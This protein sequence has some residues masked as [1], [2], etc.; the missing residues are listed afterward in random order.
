[1][2]FK[3]QILTFLLLGILSQLASAQ[4]LILVTSTTRV[5]CF[6]GSDGTMTVDNVFLGIPPYEY[7][8]FDPS[9]DTIP[10][11]SG[12]SISGL[13]DSTYKVH[14][15][16]ALLKSGT[17]SKKVDGGK[18]IVI[19]LVIPNSPDCNGGSDGSIAIQAS[20]AASPITY[21]ID[22]GKTYQASLLFPSLSA[23][24]YYVFVQ[25]ADGCDTVHI[26]NP[27][28][29]IDPL[30]LN[31]TSQS[32]VPLKCAGAPLGEISIDADGGTPPLAYALVP[33]STDITID[34]EY[35]GIGPGSYHV[36]V[37]DAKG[38]TTSSNTYVFSYPNPIV[39]TDVDSTQPSCNGTPDGKITITALGGTGDLYYNLD[40]GPTNTNGIFPGLIAG[41]YDVSITDD[42][43]CG[44]V[45]RLNI[46]VRDPPVISIKSEDTT[47]IKCNLAM[48]GV[49]TVEGE[50]GTPPYDYTLL[51]PPTVFVD[52]DPSGTFTGFPAANGYYV[53]VTDANNC[54]PDSS[55][56]W[57]FAEPP[58]IVIDDTTLVDVS[59][60]G[61]TNGSIDV[62]AIGGTGTLTY[63]ISGIPPISKLDNDDGV[64]TGLPGGTYSVSV[65]DSKTCGPTVISNLVIID[66]PLLEIT[67]ADSTHLLCNGDGNGSITVYASGGTGTR[68]FSITGSG[69]PDNTLGVFS[70]L[71]GGIY[72]VEVDDENLCGPVSTGNIE[73]LEPDL[74]EIDTEDTTSIKCNLAKDG[75]ITVKGK[76]GT[77]PYD[78]TLL[79][80]P[81]VF[82][83][84]DPSGT[85]TGFPAA[86]GY[87][88]RVTDA[89]NCPPDSSISWD[90]AEPSE[91]VIDDTTLADISCN[92]LT[93]GSI[94]V[95]ASGGATGTLIYSIS[96]APP[97]SKPDNNDGIFTG[98]PAGTYSV[99]VTNAYGCGP[100]V[101]NNLVINEPDPIS[102]TFA[103][104]INITCN[105]DNDG[106]IIILATGGTDP[107]RY[108]L[109]DPLNPIDTNNLGTF[110][111]LPGGVYSVDVS[112]TNNC[113]A[114]NSGNLN[115]V[116]P[117]PISITDQDTTP[118]ICFE[119]NNGTI[120][121][122]ASGGTPLLVYSLTPGAYPDNNDGIFT[123]IVPDVGYQVSVTDDNGCT[124]ALSNKW[125]FFEPAAIVLTPLD[126]NDVTC[127]TAGDGSLSVIAAEG[128]PPYMYTLTPG[129]VS[130]VN[131]GDFYSL[132]GDTYSVSVTD[133][134]ACPPDVVSDMVVNEPAPITISNIDT[135]DVSC[136]LAGDGSIIVTAA[137][138]TGILYY[139][140]TPGGT[141][142]DNGSFVGLSGPSYDLSI[143][144]DNTCPPATAPNLLVNDPDPI[145]IDL[146][147]TLGISC[148]GA[149]DARI[150]IKASGGTGVLTFILKNSTVNLDTNTN[151][152]FIELP[153]ETYT[154]EVDDENGCGPISSNPF[155]FDDPDTI[156][157][158]VNLSS[159][160]A[161]TCYG[162]STGSLNITVTGGRAPYTYAWSSPN[163]FSGA[164]KNISGLKAGDYYLTVT[165][166]RICPRSYTPLDSIT[167]PPEFLMSITKKDMSCFGATDDTVWVNAS[168]GN[169][170]YQYDDGFGPYA[171]NV[172][173]NLGPGTHTLEVI[174]SKSCII[175]DTV[176]I[177]MP[178]KLEI[179]GENVVDSLQKCNGDSNGIIVITATGGTGLLEYSIDSGYTFTLNN[180]FTGLGGN[181]YYSAVKDQNGCVVFKS[182][183]LIRNPSVLYID[184]YAQDDIISC[185]DAAEGE[186][187]IKAAGGTP[188]PGINPY[189]YVM[190]LAD[191]T[192]DGTFPNLIAGNHDIDI[193]DANGC[194]TDTSIVILSPPPITT[195]IGITDVSTCYE[196]STGVIALKASG[197][198]GLTK[199]YIFL[200]DTTF[201]ADT[202]FYDSLRGGNYDFTVLDSMGCEVYPSATVN[203]PD[204]ISTDS[205]L[206][207]PVS[208]YGD[209]NGEI[210]VYA[211]GGTPPYSYILNPGADTNSTGVYSG[212]DPGD[213]TVTIGD[214]PGC[215]PYTTPL[216]T[217]IRPPRLRF[218]SSETTQI[219]CGGASDGTI[220]IYAH[221]GTL[222]YDYSV[223]S[224]VPFD[225]SKVATGLGP[226]TYIIVVQD[227]SGCLVIGD[228]ITLANPAGLGLNPSSHTDVS[229]CFGDSTGAITVS[230]TGGTGTLQYSLDSVIWQSAGTF[231]GLPAGIYTVLVRD[232][233][234]CLSAFPSDTISE[235]PALSVTITTATAMIP[236]PGSITI[237]ASGGTPPLQYSIDSGASF[238][239]QTFYAVVSDIYG[240]VVRDTN[241]CTHEES[242]TVPASPPL[243]VSISS[244]VIDC[245]NNSNGSIAL[246]AL[247]GIGTVSYSIEGGSNPNS[248]GDFPDLGGGI[249][250]INVADSHRI[251]RDTLVIIN[252]PPFDVSGTISPATCARN[253]FDG[254]ITLAVSGATPPYTYLWS[255]GETTKDISGLEE[256]DYQVTIT[257]LHA[258]QFTENYSVLANVSLRADAGRDTIVCY[259]GVATLNG[260][261]G[262]VFLW[263]PE[264]GLS[265][266][267]VA[268]PQ[269]TVTDSV[270]Y[271]LFARDQ[272][273]G[274]SD[275]DTVM[276]SVHPYRGISAGQDTTVAPGQIITLVATGGP[277]ASY[278]WLP[279]EGIDD[280]G[281]QST[282]ATIGSDITYMVTG[283]TEFGCSESDSMSISVATGLMIYS[284]FTPNDDGINDFWDID[285]IVYYPNATVKV[286]DRWGKTVFSSIGY[287][288]NQRWD[289]KYKDK[290]LP[291]GTYYYI[292]DLKDGSEPSTGPVTIV[293]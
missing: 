185:F 177:N 214:T 54:A 217:V 222:P 39:I 2:R 19:D 71:S 209:K 238:S 164:T 72:T 147:D 70:P 199:G 233:L 186:V 178:Q 272:A 237:S 254:F 78:Y 23:G 150:E 45:E 101:I 56:S 262:D 114:K 73:I 247:N 117:L 231:P 224:G 270:S 258:C 25:N 60:N 175:S 123:G 261:G 285:Y 219:S 47:S 27:V 204:S 286:F 269:T 143:T 109:K 74:I 68:T 88:V 195:S 126:T 287:A 38:C 263:S 82:V 102:I 130:Q 213:Y 17:S 90:F 6:G 256:K 20:S 15:Y 228:T 230:A 89:N 48:D 259:G 273:S 96:G 40:P 57:D 157:V 140:L 81:T 141:Q 24:D 183:L 105:G 5:T 3:R 239:A 91:I 282:T 149:D 179:V 139:T 168:G 64:F 76:G 211:A 244:S 245:Y 4:G 293:R 156:G 50:G 210:R 274:C 9:G 86:N 220:T 194:T 127:T 85:F 104:K 65:T 148:N 137:G 129:G 264:E 159:S 22:S 13:Y 100:A 253:S 111:L 132:S 124:P 7:F 290:E 172:F 283:T 275:R 240:V 33:D 242:V 51:T 236:D 49:I 10:G 221:G 243:D 154:V 227:A 59:C 136:N 61:G 121:I 203:A 58:A 184:K 198:T 146:E 189:I 162:D 83:D 174:D 52:N 69:L 41:F 151:G 161:L 279:A 122:E 67:G 128:T 171:S 116:D 108:I 43:G 246:S 265:R 281:G 158:K 106:Q 133:S 271:V 11:E 135:N 18:E 30:V 201:S 87:Y 206:V 75:I 241:L 212:L 176:T 112:D 169:P 34:G 181:T 103:N 160:K 107:L 291:I 197:G 226:D 152:I 278:Q 119:D 225:T 180:T 267:D 28:T 79:T 165:D 202:V 266:F 216:L 188:I 63:S 248:T 37:S 80:P 187:R 255:N 182:S 257:D 173:I 193:Y 190:D 235:P 276:L 191:T 260:S 36:T 268:N 215:K 167:G 196:D 232:S 200:G 142:P 94:D 110:D 163:G 32:S 208:C 66:P 131:D 14:V 8:W 252:P 223:K 153:P 46:E 53:R 77:P 218:D 249:Y 120:T 42:N 92:L 277:F 84:N 229:S 205:V 118:I 170:G 12:P 192:L 1:M 35:S 155:T 138:G 21:S 29:L 292:I 250:Y 26:G 98:L 55:S 134:R 31:I 288:D 234:S 93:D 99:S 289:G 284:G 145:S 125:D 207:S 62:D 115:L 280:P 166:S 144:D 44:P 95:D 16:D 97:I 113:P 251:Y